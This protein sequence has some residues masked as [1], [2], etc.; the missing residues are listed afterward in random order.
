MRD[1]TTKQ[2]AQEFLATKLAE[3]GKK[4]E[5]KLN[6]ETAVTRALHVWKTLRDLI[7]AQCKEWNNI[8]Q[9][10]TL[11]CKETPLGDL[12]IWCAATAKHI[13]VH[14]DSGRLTVTIKNDARD[15][16]QKDA[17][18]QIEGYATGSGRDAR[19]VRNNEPVNVPVFILAELRILTGIG[20]Q[21]S[22]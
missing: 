11:T 12:R 22:A 3:E 5:D 10:E 20:A 14:F 15:A 1:E 7:F 8:T 6:N 17:I 4:H 16:A 21:R 9:E 2:A 19:L 13:M 18:L